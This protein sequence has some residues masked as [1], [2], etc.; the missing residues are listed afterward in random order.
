MQASENAS[1]MGP[2][3]SSVHSS[4]GVKESD[5]KRQQPHEIDD[6]RSDDGKEAHQDPLLA[7]DSADSF[8]SNCSG[9]MDMLQLTDD[10]LFHVLDF[11]DIAKVLTGC[12]GISRRFKALAR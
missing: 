2:C 11:L 5:E 6:N 1:E 8:N 9:A 4:D 12:S 3:S 7:A 10:L